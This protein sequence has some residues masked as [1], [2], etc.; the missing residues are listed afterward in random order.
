LGSQDAKG[1][2]GLIRSLTHNQGSL[3]V[4]TNSLYPKLE[5]LKFV[6]LF[7]GGVAVGTPLT[8]TAKD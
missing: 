1:S 7:R 8:K 4:T 3:S 5:T 2:I 6:T